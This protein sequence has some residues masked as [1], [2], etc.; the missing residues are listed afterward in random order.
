M[1]E[2]AIDR[3]GTGE[4]PRLMRQMRM[5]QIHDDP[6]QKEGIRVEAIHNERGYREVRAKLARQY[7][8]RY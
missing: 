7:D 3:P 4:L 8:Y 5:F 1:P 6:A 2:A